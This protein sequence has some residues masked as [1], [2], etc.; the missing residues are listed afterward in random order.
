MKVGILVIAFVI[1]VTGA[2]PYTHAQSPA[3]A[4]T[5]L[6]LS[7]FGAAT[8]TRTGLAGGRN[9]GVTAGVDL[10]VAHLSFANA[11][12]EVRSS[13]PFSKGSTDAYQDLLGGLNFSRVY[14]RYCPYGDVLFGRTQIEYENGGYPNP[15]KTYLYTK[16]PSNLL[17][18]GGGVDYDFNETWAIKADLQW[19]RYASPVAVSGYLNAEAL[20]LG[21]VYRINISR[22]G[23]RRH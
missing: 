1:L 19:Q 7:G 18:A 22:F 12:V 2:S 13:Y 23:R 8:G 14:G 6:T 4:T 17:S 9:I 20:S 3:S 15:A 5:L 16:S 11:S 21:A 10:S